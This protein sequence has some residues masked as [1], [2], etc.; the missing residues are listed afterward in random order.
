MPNRRDFLKTTAVAAAGTI[1][2]PSF[3]LKPRPKVVVLGAGFA[4]LA[5]AAS[6]V[7]KGV[8]VTVLEAR[9]RVGGRVFSQKVHPERSHVVELG[10]EWVGASHERIIAMCNEFGL[11]LQD[12]RF[13]THLIYQG[14]YYPKDQWK[15]SASWENQW[16]NILESYPHLSEADKLRLDQMDWWRYLVNNGMDGMDLDIRELLDSTDF[17]ESIRHVSAFA[18]LAEYAESSEKNEM[19]FKIKGGNSSLADALADRISSAR[20][21]TGQKVVKVDQSGKIIKVYVQNGDVFEADKVICALPTFAVNQV[22]WNPGLPEDKKTALNALQYARINKNVLY[23]S[24]RFW[25]DESFDMVTDG[26]AHYF[27]H[28]TKNQEGPEG[29]LISY[30]IGDKAALIARQD[31]NFRS[32]MVD[33]ALRPAF[34]KTRNYLKNQLMYYWGDDNYSKGAYAIYRPGQWFSV[35][36]VLRKPHKNVFFAGEHIADWQGF[37]EGAINT[38]EDAAAEIAD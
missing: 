4:G 23:Y 37:M 29:A 7:K 30:T 15:Y 21:I 1:I 8:D 26:P 33:E 32:D 10:A 14:K 16:K 13:D 11:E 5:A 20:I 3:I 27:Y 18:A 28:A 31:E 25:Q 35:L 22:Q 9:N 34:G 12:N 38:G 6:L 24:S 2:A 19:D 17:G 36:P